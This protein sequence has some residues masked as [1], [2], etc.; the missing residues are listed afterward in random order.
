MAGTW[1]GGLILE[2]ITDVNFRR[3]TRWI[4]TAVGVLYLI[5]GAQL[6]MGPAQ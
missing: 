1:C 3:W 4:V 2:R 5:Q 6:L